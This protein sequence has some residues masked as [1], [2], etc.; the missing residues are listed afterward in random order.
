[1]TLPNGE[2]LQPKPKLRQNVVGLVPATG[3]ATRITPLPCSKEL[4]PIG[5]GPIG[6]H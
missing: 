3:R 4:Y 6:R 2:R 5:L 1:M